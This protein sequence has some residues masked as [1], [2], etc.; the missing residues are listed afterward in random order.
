MFYF[1]YQGFDEVFINSANSALIKIE[2][3]NNVNVV[4]FTS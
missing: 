2:L 1:S 4:N 3:V